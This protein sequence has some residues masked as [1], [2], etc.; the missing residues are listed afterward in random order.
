VTNSP[1]NHR[2]LSTPQL[3]SVLLSILV[4][5]L[6][7]T[8]LPLAQAQTFTTLH[9][10]TA[11]NDGAYPWA[12]LVEDNVGNLY[13]TAYSGGSSRGGV[14]FQVSSS[15]VETVLYDFCS[16][17]G[18]VDGEY[19]FGPV[20]RDKTGNLYGTTELGGAY[21]IGTVFM[22]DTAGKETV[23]HSF[24]GYPSDGCAP[25]GGL[26]LDRYGNLYGTTPTCGANSEGAMFKVTKKGTYTLLHSFGADSTDGTYPND[27]TPILDKKGNIYGF[28]QYGGGT[29]CYNGYHYGC[30]VVYRMS[31]KR[32]LTVLY[33][34]A[35]GTTDGCNP[36]GTP[37]MDVA[38]NLY[39]TTDGC[40]PFTYGT[41]WKLSQKGAETILHNF[42]GGTSD[43]CFPIGG[44]VRDSRGKLYG[45]TPE[46]G[47]SNNGTVWELSKGTLT[48]LH[49]FTG[50][51]GSY[52]VGDLL[53][54]S[55][56]GLY[57]TS[58]QGGTGNYGTVWAY[59]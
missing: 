57:G 30:G 55:K 8:Q 48:L 21:G 46:C 7:V 43:G 44:V 51:D 13:G 42:G 32:K 2:Q 56:G 1:Q 10:F 20:I 36:F 35:G 3:A 54:D 33:A 22:L 23:L 49:S 52:P 6:G 37:G 11:G 50:S 45:N 58:S 19:P 25:T 34:F 38:G 59:K 27:T 5:A 4:L 40:G 26:A 17:S 41:V 16:V 12:G 9:N 15:G 29:G 47:A 53:R 31:T 18:C 24:A 39:G 14:V 28:T